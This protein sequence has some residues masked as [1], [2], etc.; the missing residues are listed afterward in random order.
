[1][2]SQWAKSVTSHRHHCDITVWHHL[3]RLMWSYCF[4][5]VAKTKSFFAGISC[6]EII[7]ITIS[8]HII[9]YQPFTA[10]NWLLTSNMFR[11]ELIRSWVLWHA[12]PALYHCTNTSSHN[13][14]QKLDLFTQTKIS[15][16]SLNDENYTFLY[17]FFTY[18]IFALMN[19]SYMQPNTNNLELD[20]DHIVHRNYNKTHDVNVELKTI[21]F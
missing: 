8:Y 1:M 2:K 9:L 14:D 4:S 7:T 21:C 17:T 20:I 18:I 3:M 11:V 13:L 10:N 19:H 6:L 5:G 15:G 16:L 12:N